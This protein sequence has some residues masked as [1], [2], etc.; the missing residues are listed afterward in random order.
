MEPAEADEV[1]A[2]WTQLN[3]ALG[4]FMTFRAGLLSIVP[5]MHDEQ[6]DNFT[7]QAHV[8]FAVTAARNLVRAVELQAELT[9]LAT[10]S[11][12]LRSAIT[13]FHDSLPGLTEVRNVLEHFDDYLR[14]TGRLQRSSAPSDFEVLFHDPHDDHAWVMQVGNFRLV[15][16]QLSAAIDKLSEAVL[17]AAIPSGRV[18]DAIASAI[19]RAPS[20]QPDE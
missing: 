3:R 13:E 6:L 20:I 10:A 4:Y 9:D 2:Q 16:D 11:E 18:L 1:F 14:G 15:P 5:L 7:R 19:A 8:F 12:A 17:W